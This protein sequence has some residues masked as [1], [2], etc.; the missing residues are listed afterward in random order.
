[1]VGGVLSEHVYRGEP[2]PQNAIASVLEAIEWHAEQTPERDAI[3]FPE[4][5]A[6]MSWRSLR[7]SALRSAARLQEAGV[8]T[9]DLV[10][11]MAR[12]DERCVTA[13]L[14]AWYL[15]ASAAAMPVPGNF[16]EVDGY[17]DQ[18]R[19]MIAAGGLQHVVHDPSYP[20]EHAEEAVRRSPNV[21]WIDSGMRPAVRVP[22]PIG[23][24]PFPADLALVQYTSGSTSAPKGVEL[25]HANLMA[26]IAAF[27]MAT[28]L[29][30]ADSW[31]VWV[32][33]FHDFGMISTMTALSFGAKVWMSS[34]TWF[35]RNPGRWLA[36]FGRAGITH[37]SGPN[38]SFDIM[39]DSA[40]DE[41]FEGVSL[42]NWRVAINAAEPVSATTVRSF[43]KRF[44][45]YGFRGETMRPTYGLAEATLM[46][47]LPAAKTPPRVVTVRREAITERRVAV[48]AAAGD[49]GARSIVSV[50]RTMP[51]IA[52]RIVDDRG[53]TLSDRCVGEIH[54]MGAAV[55]RGYRGH[56]DGAHDGW[57]ATGDLGFMDSGELF[58]CGRIKDVVIVRGTK[59][60]PEDLEPLVGEIDGVRRGRC[61]VVGVGETHE[62]L[63]VIAETRLEGGEIRRIR[64][65]IR[66]L[67]VRRLG[68][69]EIEVYMVEPGTVA[70]TSS[71]K[72][73][74]HQMRR[75]LEN[76][77]IVDLEIEATQ[78]EIPVA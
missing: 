23:A 65:E 3:V 4:T 37:F 68:I 17:A 74:R 27:G 47:S 71:G 56:P 29:G 78:S 6:T 50:G 46:L 7:G 1:M 73:R 42:A 66:K 2:L 72:L 76:G 11:V 39:R 55:T 70:M 34:P 60:H 10:G 52:L 13:V 16:A 31:G 15:R 63:A 9:G 41:M 25:T 38:F 44:E 69:S 18:I 51:G 40:T 58:I 62:R 43:A 54:A 77:R 30:A 61:C 24:R 35:I 21:T 32:P 22:Q 26:G 59:Y 14:G 5:G 75:L 12:N 45:P 67:L 64:N 53:K 28:Q 36:L 57:W 20:S 19:G 8:K 48:P 33:L 49:P